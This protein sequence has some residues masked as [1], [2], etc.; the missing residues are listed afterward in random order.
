MDDI[1][2]QI[3]KLIKSYKEKVIIGISGHGAFGK[4]TFANNLMKLLDEDKV[5]YVNTDSY[6]I[7]SSSVR[8]YTEIDYEYKNEKHTY[9]MTACHPGAHNISALERDINMIKKSLEF[10]T[11]DTHYEKSYL[12]SS[13][14]KINIIEGMSVAFTDSDLFDVKIFLYTDGETE[15]MRRSS[16]DILERG[17]KLDY[18]KRSHEERR[19]QYDI[20]MHPHRKD[21]DI[22]IKNTNE[23]YFIERNIFK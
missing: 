9:K 17:T 5:N 11:L 18:L 1:L 22:V 8:K 6:I 23:D 15:I 14:N 3:A 2:F 20:F 12:V 13:K 19:I 7:G 4:T 21:F 16:R 10:Y